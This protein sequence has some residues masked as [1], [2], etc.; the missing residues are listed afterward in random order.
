MD[1]AD[2]LALYFF[3]PKKPESE[4]AQLYLKIA[5][6]PTAFAPLFLM[7]R[8]ILLLAGTF[9]EQAR[10]DVSTH[11][12]AFLLVH[13]AIKTA[14]MLALGKTTV[15]YQDFLQ[16]Y[17][18]YLGLEPIDYVGLRLLRNSIEHNNFQLFMRLKADNAAM[19]QEL[20]QYLIAQGGVSP[21]EFRSISY[22]KVAFSLYEKKD[23]PI[24]GPPHLHNASNTDFGVIHFG[25][26]PFAFLE[27]FERGVQ[28]LKNDIVRSDQLT[29]FFDADITPDNWMRVS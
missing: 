7:R 9:G 13:I 8:Q 3:D 16:F 4:Y 26:D 17:K 20:K 18:A 28:K 19:F 11:L 2:K 10:Q 1:V 29:A 12:P 6:P 21:S 5:K 15:R 23:G 25:I 22:F 27:A 14:T 24:V